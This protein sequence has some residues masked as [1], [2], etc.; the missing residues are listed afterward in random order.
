MGRYLVE[1]DER[2]GAPS[3]VVIGESV[4]RNRFGGDP[5][6]VGRIL[7]LGATPYSVVGVMPEG[8][9]FPVDDTFGRRSVRENWFGN[10]VMTSSRSLA[11]SRRVRRFKQHRRRPCWSRREQ[12][13]ASRIAMRN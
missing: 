1:D 9:A 7:Q 11:G 10:P 13:P 12:R 8:F 5:A 6:I 4:W 3:V 2:E